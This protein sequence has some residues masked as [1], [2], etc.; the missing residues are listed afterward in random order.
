[1]LWEYYIADS[2]PLATTLKNQFIL[3][4]FQDSLFLLDVVSYCERVARGIYFDVFSA[5]FKGKKLSQK[6]KFLCNYQSN[7]PR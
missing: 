1:M 2:N 7:C 4:S 5:H 3:E 6:N